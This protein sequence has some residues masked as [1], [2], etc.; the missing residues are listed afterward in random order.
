MRRPL[1][2]VAAVA[3]LLPLAGCQA[4]GPHLQRAEF[5]EPPAMERTLAQSG[6]RT[7]GAEWPDDQ[8][9]RRFRNGELDRVVEKALADNQGL[10]KAADRLRQTEAITEIEGARLLPMLDFDLGMRQSRIPN[11]GVVASYNPKLAGRE[12]TMAFI[13]PLSFRYEFDFWGKNRAALDAALG[14]TAAQEAEYAQTRLLLAAGAA[15]AYFR[16]AAAARQVAVAQ[17]MTKLRRELVRLAQSRFRTGIDTQDQIAQATAEVEAAVKREAGARGL[18]ALQ[19]D[20]LARL[21]GEGP[22]AA[23]DLFAHKPGAAAAALALPAHLPIELLA[24]RPD[25]AAAMHRAEAASERIYVA[26][27]EFLP[28]IDLVGSAGLEASVNSTQISKLASYLFRASAFSYA[29]SPGFHLPLFQGGRLS[30]KLEGRRAEYDEAVDSYNETLLAA[31]QQVADAI[32]NWKQTRAALDAQT[33]LVAARRNELAL[34]RTR[35]NTGVRDRREIVMLAHG[36]MEQLYLRESL[37]ADHRAA[38]V[39]LFQALGGGYAGGPQQPRP[40]IDPEADNLTP[41]VEAIQSLG[42]G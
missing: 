8:W 13:N 6:A 4:T 16:G 17:E 31:A 38:M 18:L 21:M 41:I 19:Q 29:V 40:T 23:R 15:R 28:S 26:K 12:K 3:G 20:L 11:H 25:L 36:V 42:G 14:E 34:A 39:D 2:R 32:A 10:Q 1:P 22:D 33:R 9:W 27:A 35:W 24:H 5:L 30:G 7:A 37:E